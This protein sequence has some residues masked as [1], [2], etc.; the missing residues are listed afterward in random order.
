MDSPEISLAR[1]LYP[2]WSQGDYGAIEWAHPEIDFAIADGPTPGRWRGIDAMAQ[3]FTDFIANFEAWRVEP[4][5]FQDLGNGRVL[6]VVRLR[7]R[8]RSSGLEVE[9]IGV[10]GANLFEIRAG[11]VTRLTIYLDAARARADAAD[12][13]RGANA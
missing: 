2:R 11:K 8:G 13:N 7:A 5:E 12:A 3:A 4:I 10:L 6:V 9:R 1:S